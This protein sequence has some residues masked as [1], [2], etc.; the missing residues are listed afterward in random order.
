MQ[1]NGLTR[2]EADCSAG[3]SPPNPVQV[4]RLELGIEDL[5]MWPCAVSARWRRRAL[6]ALA[7]E[8]RG[9]A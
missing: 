2:F 6:T 4:R 1:S 8:A 9:A 3:D 5:K 7:P